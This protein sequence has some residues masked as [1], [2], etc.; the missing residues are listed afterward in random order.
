M[1]AS[2]S[3]KIL[4]VKRGSMRVEESEKSGSRSKVVPFPKKI[5]IMIPVSSSAASAASGSTSTLCTRE[6]ALMKWT[7][8]LRS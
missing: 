3:L 8:M 4:D 1:V 5:K 6:V 7:V 2:S